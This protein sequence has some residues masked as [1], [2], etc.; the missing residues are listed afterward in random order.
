MKLTIYHLKN[1]DSCKKAIKALEAHKGGE[2]DMTLVDVRADGIGKAELEKMMAQ[3]G[4]NVLVNTRS[5]TW[6][7][8]SDQEKAGLDDTKALAL[9]E[10]HPTLMKRPVINDGTSYHVGWSKSVQEIFL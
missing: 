8:L 5:T 4:H 1:C 6:R 3:I 10:A 2:Y 7:N 9:L